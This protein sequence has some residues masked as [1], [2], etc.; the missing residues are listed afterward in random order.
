MPY[1]ICNKCNIYY[2]IENIDNVP[3]TCECGNPLKYYDAIEEYMNGGENKAYNAENHHKLSNEGLLII[4]NT[5]RDDEE[6][7]QKEHHLRELNYQIRHSEEEQ[8]EKTK[9]HP[10]SYVSP[11]IIELKGNEYK[12]KKEM[13]LREIE[14]L[15][16][17]REKNI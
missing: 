3:D 4:T 9:I 10:E 1:L 17:D 15:K 14:L 5:L 7:E 2:E 11:L 6:R 13:L 12:N 16:E 8:E